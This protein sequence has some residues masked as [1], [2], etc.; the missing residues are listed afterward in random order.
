[1]G[2]LQTRL[3]TTALE[4]IVE[5]HAPPRLLFSPDG[6][7][8]HPNFLRFRLGRHDGV[9]L[10][11]QAKQPGER[12]VSHP[13]ELDVDFE[14]VLG[15][16]QEAYERLLG[17]AL[18]GNPARFAREDGVENAWRVVQPL[19]DQPGT[20]HRYRPGSWGPPQADVVVA[21]HQGWHDPTP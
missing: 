8:P 18:D 21:G 10:S 2:R 14:R 3:A 6:C 17:D 1:M 12:L 19:L 11:V 5:L 7:Q 13:V 9:T 16:R 4:V 15:A 20:V